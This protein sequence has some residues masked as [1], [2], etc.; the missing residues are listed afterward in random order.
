MLIILFFEHTWPWT[1]LGSLCCTIWLQARL[2]MCS[3]YPTSCRAR[4]EPAGQLITGRRCCSRGCPCPPG[5]SCLFGK[6]WPLGL[7]CAFGALSLPRKPKGDAL[8]PLPGS[9][10]SRLWA[11]GPCLCWGWDVGCVSGGMFVALQT[12]KGSLKRSEEVPQVQG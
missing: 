8:Q 12:R 4:R 5:G 11:P 2:K 1:Q 3:N 9:E 7:S 10:L 6:R